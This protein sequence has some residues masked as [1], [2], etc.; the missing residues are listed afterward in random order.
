[1]TPSVAIAG[2]GVGWRTARVAYTL[3]GARTLG[4]PGRGLGA[5]EGTYRE[6]ETRLLRWTVLD[7]VSLA[8]H[9]QGALHAFRFALDH[10]SRVTNL[11]LVAGPFLGAHMAKGPLALGVAGELG[12]QSRWLRQLRERAHRVQCPVTLVA[13]ANDLLVTEDSAHGLP[14][15][16]ARRVT[17]DHGHLSLMGSPVIKRLLQ[18]QPERQ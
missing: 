5:L 4:L 12:T 14:L 17:L 9:S 6:L 15:P 3:W 18:N 2:T 8:G 16:S 1:M 11:V 13:G 7:P 10:P